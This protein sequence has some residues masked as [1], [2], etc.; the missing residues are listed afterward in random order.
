[1]ANARTFSEL[2][3]LRYR[4]E[5]TQYE[6]L[7]LIEG[8]RELRPYSRSVQLRINRLIERINY[9]APIIQEDQKRLRDGRC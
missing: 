3:P 6:V 7:L 8:L 4:H 1:M 5:F 2:A 9:A